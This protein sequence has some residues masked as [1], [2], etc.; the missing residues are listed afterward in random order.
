MV[1]V[2]LTSTETVELEG[3]LYW[4]TNARGDLRIL[5]RSGAVAQFAGGTWARVLKKEEA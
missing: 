1:I 4:E 3:E 2:V 5:K